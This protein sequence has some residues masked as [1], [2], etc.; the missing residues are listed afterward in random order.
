MFELL[1]E[2]NH[3]IIANLIEEYHFN[4]ELKKVKEMLVSNFPDE[5]NGIEEYFSDNNIKLAVSC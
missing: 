5:K 2:V 3:I 4:A 1:M